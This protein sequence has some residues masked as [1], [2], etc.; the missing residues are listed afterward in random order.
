MDKS[1]KLGGYEHFVI[2]L[3]YFGSTA[4]FIYPSFLTRSTAGSYW[5]PLVVWCAAAVVCSWLYA[6]LLSRLQGRRLLTELKRSVGWAPA[7]LLCLPLF[8][9]LLGALVVMLRSYAEVITMTMLPTTPI[10]FLNGMILA[11]ALLASAGVMPIVRSA[12]VLVLFA[13][14]ASV[15]L[16]ILGWSNLDWSMGIP[17]AR[18]NGDFIRNNQFYAGSCLWM[19][20][21]ITALIQPYSHRSVAVAWRAY[22]LALLCALPMIAGYIYL[23]VLT[24]GRELTSQLT[25][26]FV[27][28]MDSIYHYWVIVENLGAIFVTVSLLYVLVIL[29]LKLHV[30][31]ETVRTFLPPRSSKMTGAVLVLAVFLTATFIP[32]WR[33]VELVMV[34]T[35]GL[36]LYVMF[37]FPLLGIAL[38]HLAGRRMQERAV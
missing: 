22:G 35:A 32:S 10:A 1:S 20:F 11:P 33:D 8:V 3:L 4:G 17:W 27:S 31:N 29:A 26:P 7:I 12:K 36:R 9:S 2:H 13:V 16:L 38:L 19:G 30:L 14:P 5:V 34:L 24:F 18:F 6:L 23:P 28:K 21:V 15:T 37:V 25:V